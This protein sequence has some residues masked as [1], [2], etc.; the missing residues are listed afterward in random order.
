ML[1]E[2]RRHRIDLGPAR[3]TLLLRS[4]MPP[5]GRLGVALAL[6]AALAA[7]AAAFVAALALL[8]PAQLFPVLAAGLILAAAALALIACVA[9]PETGSARI[10]YWEVAGLLALIGL[11]AVFGE[12][13]Q[14][15][16]LFSREKA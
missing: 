2:P 9:P 14:A 7:A 15:V 1:W 11:A 5:R 8:P 3:S 13:E 10:F 12:P 16:A 6:G 4:I